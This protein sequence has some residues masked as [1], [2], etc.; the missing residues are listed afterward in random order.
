[1]GARLL[2]T[3]YWVFGFTSSAV[4]FVGALAIFLITAPFDRRGV[5]IHRYT[6][7]WAS[8]Y[9]WVHPHWQVT[10][11]GRENARGGPYVIVAN[12]Q[13]TLD[14][15]V[16]FRLFIHFKWVAKA[17]VFLV[18]FIGWNMFLN[19]YVRLRRGSKKSIADMMAASERKLSEGSSILIFPEG[20]RSRD[21][22]LQ[23][24]KHGAFT[25]AKRAQ[26]P[27]VPVVI[28]GSG[29]ALPR[30]GFVSEGRHV[31]RIR[32]LPEIP[33]D[34]FADASVPELAARVRAIY[35]EAL[36]EPE[37]APVDA[38]VAARAS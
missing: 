19:R 5:I 24:F 9:S 11:E 35:V 28:E 6:C 16:L 8:I 25:L 15:L 32:V 29:K 34:S 26:V 13:S 1:M 27:I 2:S 18:P 14:I 4:F 31:I 37:H 21:G 7:L 3:A 17:E 20:T 12:H 23:P 10:I 30:R 33:H 22:R 36:G 38:P